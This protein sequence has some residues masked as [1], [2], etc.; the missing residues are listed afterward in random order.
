MLTDIGIEPSTEIPQNWQDSKHIRQ[1]CTYKV[2]S[3]F[4]EEAEKLIE[5]IDGPTD[6]K[7][8][9]Q[10]RLRMLTGLRVETLLTHL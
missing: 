10:R 1:H 8:T 9:S 5:R 4:F 2:R 6:Q 3:G 7:N